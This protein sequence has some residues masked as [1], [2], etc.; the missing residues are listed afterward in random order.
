MFSVL[1]VQSIGN[2]WPSYAWDFFNWEIFVPE[3]DRV[4]FVT[5][6]PV[7]KYAL[8]CCSKCWLLFSIQYGDLLNSA[9]RQ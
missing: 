2:K 9:T 1:T 4:D 8:L 7:E 3:E 6:P 5:K